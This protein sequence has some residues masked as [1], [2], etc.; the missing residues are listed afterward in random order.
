[1]TSS[2][3]ITTG[4]RFLIEASLQPSTL[5]R[6]RDAVFQFL[7]W[8]TENNYDAT[9]TEEL[10]DLLTDYLH[11]LYEDNGGVGKT[12]ASH[13]IFGLLK[14]LPR[15]S[16]HLPTAM[17]SLQGWLKLR[18]STSYPPLT[19]ELAVVLACHLTSQSHLRQGVGLLLSFDCLLRVGELVGLRKCDVADSGDMRLGAEYR[20]TALR[21]RHTK[22]GPN[23]WVQVENSAVR[24]LLRCVVRSTVRSTDLLFPFSAASYRTKFKGA[25]ADLG[26]SSL[27]VPHSLRH[28]GATRLHL[29]GRSLEDI[30]MRGRW[31]STKSARRY[32]QAGRAL[33][34]NARV[35]QH[36][37]EVG[38]ILAGDV[39]FALSRALSQ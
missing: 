36:L 25:C 19:W 30:L 22:T 23:Q 6:Y 24:D 35:P 21:L 5:S 17:A 20:G 3:S 26:L 1:M 28:G 13:T 29:L 33:L 18:P 11:E 14:Y 34:L 4:R 31:Q 37:V 39:V 27:Y 7:D 32:I 15:C 38:S 8:C 12:T 16:G 2:S 9:T 10:D